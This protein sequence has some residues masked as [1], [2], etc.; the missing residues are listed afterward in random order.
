MA[1]RGGET[2]KKKASIRQSPLKGKHGVTTKKNT[3]T[4]DEADPISAAI[5]QVK[6]RAP[7]PPVEMMMSEDEE[8]GGGQFFVPHRPKQKRPTRNG[9]RYTNNR[10]VVEQK[11]D[12]ISN[13]LHELKLEEE[14]QE[15][16]KSKVEIDSDNPIVS[17]LKELKSRVVDNKKTSTKKS[18]SSS[19]ITN[20]DPIGR[21]LREMTT[22]DND[23][24][25]N[26]FA[27]STIRVQDNFGDVERVPAA[28]RKSNRS[29]RYKLRGRDR[30]NGML[31]PRAVESSKLSYQRRHGKT[32]ASFS[33]EMKE[34]VMERERIERER[35]ERERIEREMIERERQEKEKLERERLERE[36][37]ERL[38]RER[39]ERER[40]E[41]E[42]VERLERERL[43]RER[44]ERERIERE[45]LERLER[46]RVEKER[47]EKQR[48]EK[49]RLEKERIEKQR[50][51]KQRREEEER[52]NKAS[53]STEQKESF[54]D[55]QKREIDRVL[56][57]EEHDHYSILG[58]SATEFD[59]KT[60]LK[61]FRRL[62]RLIHPDKN[63]EASKKL[64][65]TAFRRIQS[66]R[67]VLCSP[68]K[69]AA[70]NSARKTR[71]RRTSSSFSRHQNRD[72]PF[73]SHNSSSSSSSYHNN[74]SNNRGN[75][76]GFQGSS[77]YEHGAR[78][79]RFP[80]AWESRWN[81]PKTT[82]HTQHGGFHNNSR[83]SFGYDDSRPKKREDRSSSRRAASGLGG[84]FR[85]PRRRRGSFF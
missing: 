61:Q 1:L 4:N 53:S 47:L 36:R 79:S 32:R 76:Q 82:F 37:V 20:D 14:R 2:K 40:L 39:I 67:E 74:F 45:R 21:A 23:P 72:V 7:S 65:E 18:S 43:E 68:S 70:Y 64:A 34:N 69:R 52:K 10:R 58:I 15:K 25:L 48:L 66:A 26:V 84:M 80:S 6:A 16:Q 62:A 30:N 41:R 46:E 83:S 57:C 3:G 17:A 38:E 31:S 63:K 50:L 5:H 42:R 73:S 19:T 27:T 29:R 54:E 24:R 49:Q 77:H 12:P 51:E 78:Q 8:M 9:R 11:F 13:A 28:P 60:T 75:Q 85:G 33:S 59:R 56:R 71:Q 35:I 44:L 55:K 22:S 81:S